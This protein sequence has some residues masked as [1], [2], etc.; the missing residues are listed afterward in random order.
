MMAGA[1]RWK[2]PFGPGRVTLLAAALG[3][4]A[5]LAIVWG[6]ALFHSSP[7]S[8][9]LDARV[10]AVGNTVR[11]PVCKEPIPLNDVYNPQALQMRQFI[12]DQ[13]S[14]GVS[15]DG[16]RQELVNRY[17]PDIL[18]APPQQGFDLLIWLAPLAAVAACAVAVLLVL[19]RWSSRGH[20]PGEPLPSEASPS[21][22]SAR[23]EEI[24]DREL[25]ARE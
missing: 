9:S 21:A 6:A 5:A 2:S 3:V 17:G 18:L 8:G 19:R 13:L 22:E 24:L 7:D 20:G 25:A 11:C 15:E 1:Q 4:V 14:R 10:T 23:Y 16:V 12:R